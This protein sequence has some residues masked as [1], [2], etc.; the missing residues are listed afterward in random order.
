MEENNT[1][2]I[3]DEQT[4]SQPVE[5]QS[6]AKKIPGFRSGKT[7]KKVVAIIGYALI[8]LF[9]IMMILPTSSNN[10]P[11]TAK[12]SR[13]PKQDSHQAYVKALDFYSAKD[14][15]FA[16]DSFARVIPE[17]PDYSNAQAKI[18]EINDIQFTNYFTSA[19]E[20]LQSNQFDQAITDIDKALLNKPGTTEATNLR[21]EIVTKK[22][23]YEEK[24]KQQQITDYKNSSEVV[25]YKVL[26]KNPDSLAGKKVKL[27]G[28]IMQIQENSGDTFMLLSVTNLGYDIWNDN[29][30][31][32]YRGK[33]D[34]YEDDV[35]MIWGEVKGSFSYDSVAGWKITVPG[36]TAKYIE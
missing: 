27:T 22:A 33:A 9:L 23:A 8:G 29:V 35:I 17:D 10:N 21:A 5:K 14:Y 28:K 1:N 4:K 7:W 18:K 34:V 25:T 2:P 15:A 32:F 19:K 3:L 13:D 36:V 31:V 12:A 20:K 26:N 30:A 11:K 16:E 24:I 6:F